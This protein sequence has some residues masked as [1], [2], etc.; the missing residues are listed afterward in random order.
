MTG[1]I[2]PS[3][4][5]PP[6]A[7][8]TL[9]RLAENDTTMLKKIEPRIKDIFREAMTTLKAAKENLEAA[10]ATDPGPVDSDPVDPQMT[11][12]EGIESLEKNIQAV[13][14]RISIKIEPT[15]AT[16][17]PPQNPTKLGGKGS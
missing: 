9:T 5:T 11:S 6:Q 4:L 14:Q 16:R 7:L 3:P 12:I 1:S 10:E 13:F 15:R 2:P 8:H 17:F